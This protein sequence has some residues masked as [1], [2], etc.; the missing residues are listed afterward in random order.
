MRYYIGFGLIMIGEA[1][2]HFTHRVFIHGG[3]WMMDQDMSDCLVCT[4]TGD[5]DAYV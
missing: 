3:A 1:A 4:D 5:P 2:A